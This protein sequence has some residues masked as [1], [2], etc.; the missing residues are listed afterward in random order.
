MGQDNFT[1][2]SRASMKRE[3]VKKEDVLFLH[4]PEGC[5]NHFH[6][7][8]IAQNMTISSSCKRVWKS[9]SLVW[10]ALCPA[11]GGEAQLL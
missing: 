5:V 6:S 3:M 2:M 7:Q 10:L 1:T 8:P 9:D 4:N 11:V